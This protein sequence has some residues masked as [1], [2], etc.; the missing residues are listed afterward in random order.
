MPY[1]VTFK[2][3]TTHITSDHLSMTHDSF[4]ADWGMWSWDRSEARQVEPKT[5]HSSEDTGSTGRREFPASPS[6]L[7]EV[8][9]FC[10]FLTDH[11]LWTGQIC[12][13]LAAKYLFYEQRAT[14]MI[15]ETI[16]SLS[17]E[18]LRCDQPRRFA[19]RCTGVGVWPM[20]TVACRRGLLCPILVT[21]RTLWVTIWHIR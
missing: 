19:L 18:S 2:V 21:F 13:R 12:V 15:D 4:S 14:L 1:S 10:R 9:P 7:A 5:Q 8:V 11:R 16:S 3:S 20:M 6:R 17:C